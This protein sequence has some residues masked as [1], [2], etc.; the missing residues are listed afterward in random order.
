MLHTLHKEDND[1]PLTKKKNNK[2]SE[3]IDDDSTIES[4]EVTPP[5]IEVVAKTKKPRSE[6]QIEAFKNAQINRQKNIQLKKESQKV[7]AAKLLL[8]EK[9]NAPVAKKVKEV[10]DSS[11]DEN[12]EEV[13]IVQKRKKPKPKVKRIIVEE[14]ASES[15]SEEEIKPR[16]KNFKSQQ[17]KRSII[18]VNNN[19]LV[20]PNTVFFV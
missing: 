13:I 1:T 4:V 5:K 10:V 3:V 14:S 12:E 7:E 19:P 17:N 18:K 8:N 16:E 2:K 9:P 15:E 6:K 20:S 11:S